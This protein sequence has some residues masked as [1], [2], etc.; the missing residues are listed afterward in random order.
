MTRTEV[1]SKNTH[2]FSGSYKLNSSILDSKLESN[3]HRFWFNSNDSITKSLKF[4]KA[5]CQDSKWPKKKKVL[6]SKLL[7]KNEPF[8][9]DSILH[10]NAIPNIRFDSFKIWLSSIMTRFESSF[11]SI[12]LDSKNIDSLQSLFSGWGTRKPVNICGNALSSI[13]HFSG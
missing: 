12:W 7:K 10:D 2:S 4:D 9:V 11:D 3:F 8:L 1:T 13:T 6:C 5:K